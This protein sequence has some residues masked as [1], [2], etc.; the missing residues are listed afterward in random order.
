MK[1]SHTRTGQQGRRRDADGPGRAAA[2]PPSIAVF[3]VFG[4]T[5]LGNEVSL[6][7]FLANLR[8]RHP[9]ARVAC[10][11]PHD[12]DVASRHGL[13][14]IEMD[15][16]MVRHHFWPYY[17]WPTAKV[18]AHVAQIVTEPM[19]ARQA[20]KMIEGFDLLVVPGTGIIGD[21]G[22]GFLDVPFHLLRWCR[23]ADRASVPVCFL[24]VGAERVDS[25]LTRRVLKYAA[26]HADYRSF[27][28]TDSRENAEKIG[29]PGASTD[30]VFPD[31]AFS[32]PP[33]AMPETREV[34]WPPETVGIGVMGYYGWNEA[35]DRGEE[36]YRD[37]IGKLKEFVAW[38]LDRGFRV[39]PLMGDTRADARPLEDLVDE[40][41]REDASDGRPAFEAGSIENVDDLLREITRTD[42]V[43][44]TRFH[45]VL[46]S[47]L[48]ER[49]AISLSY[50]RKNEAL[51]EQ[52]GLG[53]LC[54][55]VAD[56]DPS[57]LIADFERTVSRGAPPTE[58][59]RRYNARFRRR[60]AEQYDE[61][62]P[63]WLER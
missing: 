55:E 62:F 22:Q 6:R 13:G 39:R 35:E 7:A 46:L 29:I 48:L 4:K 40:F 33:A 53:D 26:R 8:R 9:D 3:G 41:G 10:I 16:L 37:Y 25:L 18:A 45:N 42:L 12:S 23:A 24:S 1:P 51:M 57:R 61:I 60:L 31:L 19:R 20:R 21:F 27:R 38:L 30:P 34:S 28:N 47:L 58:E 44:G 14:L 11:G 5:N 32:L 52:M 49:P 63:D 50:S 36:I 2:E 15:P 17:E 54:Q 56:F 59:L 43:V